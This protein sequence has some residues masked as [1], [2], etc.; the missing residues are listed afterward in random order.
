MGQPEQSDGEI[1]V[2]GLN[3]SNKQYISRLGFLEIFLTKAPAIVSYL[4]L[5]TASI[6]V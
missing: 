4:R 6:F 3:N 1:F 5:E 2:L